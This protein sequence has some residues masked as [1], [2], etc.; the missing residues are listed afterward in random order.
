MSN[1]YKEEEDE[2]EEKKIR[3]MFCIYS[4]LT[5]SQVH[6]L[7]LATSASFFDNEIRTVVDEADQKRNYKDEDETSEM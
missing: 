4:R 3:L 5:C 6:R 2:D 7:T 1:S